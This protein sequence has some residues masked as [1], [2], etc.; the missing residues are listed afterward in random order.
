MS[1]KNFFAFVVVCCVAVSVSAEPKLAVQLDRSALYDGE[2]FHYQLVLSSTNPL[3]ESVV[4]DHSAWTDFD[5]QSFVRRPVQMSGSSVTMIVNGRTIRDDRTAAY[6]MQFN[7]V[8]APKRTGTL[9]I[10]LPKVIVNGKTLQPQSYIV[11]EGERQLLEDF[12]AVV[13][14][15]EPEEQDIVFLSIET[16]RN[17]LY[18]LQPLEVTLVIQIKSLPHRFATTNPLT[19]FSQVP[20]LQI[21]WAERIVRGFQ[22]TQQL[23]NWLNTLVVRPPQQRG[24]AI[25]DF[26]TSGIGFGHLPSLL[27]SGDDLLRKVPYQFSGTPRQVQRPDAQGNDTTYW[28][29]RFSRTFTAQ[30]FG[31]YSFGPVTLKGALPVAMDANAPDDLAVQRIYAVAKPATVAVVDVPQTNRPADYIGAFGTFRWDATLTPHQARVGDPMTLTLRLAGQGSTANVRSMDF[32]ANDDVAAHFRVHMP[33]TEKVD[34]Q[35]CTFTYTIRPLTAGTVE[36]PPISISV[37]DVNTE[38]FVSLSSLPISLDI[39]DAESVH[40]PTLFGGVPEGNVQLAEGG[41]F[42]NKSTLSQTFLPITFAQW[43]AVVSLF[44]AGYAAIALGVLLWRHQWTH[45]N[46][47]RGALARAKA[48]LAIIATTLSKGDSADLIDTEASENFQIPNILARQQ[49]PE[50]GKA[51]ERLHDSTGHRRLPDPAQIEISS[52]L[53]GVL[54]GYIADK[55]EGTEQGMTTDDACQRLRENRVPESLVDAIRATLESLDAIKYGG[56]DIRSLGELAH[57]ASTLLQQLDRE[58]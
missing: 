44:I 45:P 46:R 55:M 34:E 4:P 20:Q 17:R 54:F 16:D 43:A 11:A 23:E 5:I 10:P 32:S 38:R 47:Q 58:R 36:F 52:A 8:L 28:E 21:P 35:S 27:F 24:F 48:R 30:E 41:L 9:T 33:P 26:A 6:Q 15:M 49:R 22:P 1:I 57:T 50:A 13:R 3:D 31:H 53:Q 42:G 18:P 14:V 19:L 29:Y 40:A 56:L 7:Y 25:N 51:V 12:S 39:A 37:F 2:T